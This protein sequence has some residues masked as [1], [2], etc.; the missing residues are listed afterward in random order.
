MIDTSSTPVA[1]LLRRGVL[2]LGAVVCAGAVLSAG[3]GRARLQMN[4]VTGGTITP[5]APAGKAGVVFFVATDCPVSN[6][7]ATEIQRLCREYG[8]RGVGCSLIYEDVDVHPTS[9]HLDQQVR[10]HLR[11]YSYAGVPAAVDRDRTI[12]TAAKATITPLAVVVDRSGDIRYRGRIDN[13]YAALGKR[14]QQV[15]KHDLREALD[16]VLSG[17]KVPNPETEALGCYI[18]DPALLRK[19]D[20]E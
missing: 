20:H 14:R 12:A 7:Y 8:P 10:A 3:D 19:H 6:S 15:T 11:E 5:F 2:L 4:A 1:P 9:A 13:L 16:A 17:G 18:T